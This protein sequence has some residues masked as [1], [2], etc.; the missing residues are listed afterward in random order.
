MPESLSNASSAIPHPVRL[1]QSYAKDHSTHHPAES[2]ELGADGLPLPFSERQ[3]R[4]ILGIMP[5]FRSVSVG[6]LPHPPG[7]GYNLKIATQQSFDYSSFVFLGL[8]SLTAKGL[9]EHPVLGKGVHGL[10]SYTWRGFID[11]TDGTYIS[12]WFLPSLLHEDTRYYPMAPGHT[13]PARIVYVIT[14]QAVTRS[15]AGRNTTNIANLGGKALTQ[16]ISREYYPSGATSFEVLAEKF[17]YSVMRDVGFTAIR[18]FYPSVAGHY[19][20]KH[21]EKLAR[22]QQ[23]LDPTATTAAAPS[24]LP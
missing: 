16:L 3:P 7:W 9:D 20:R 17:A 4:R 10:Y 8:N 15:Y 21:H 11:K 18:E 2:V 14:R 24:P 6:A 22:Q 5:N 13:V 12:S 19:V 1:P 23:H